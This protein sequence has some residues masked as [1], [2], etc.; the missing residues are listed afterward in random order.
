MEHVGQSM[1]GKAK[2]FIDMMNSN[3]RPVEDH[4]P[5]LRPTLEALWEAKQAAQV[6]YDEGRTKKSSLAAQLNA[7]NKEIVEAREQVA[8]A[9]SAQQTTIEL[10][11][12]DKATPADLARAKQ[13]VTD[14][15]AAEVSLRDVHDTVEKALASV[16]K[17]FDTTRAYSKGAAQRYWKAV[18][19]DL[20]ADLKV[21]AG[22]QIMR[23]YA[24]HTASSNGSLPFADFLARAFPLPKPADLEKAHEALEAEHAAKF[25][26]GL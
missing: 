14:A 18:C 26:G 5:R 15:R 2:S 22:K 3:P 19:D 8:Q 12:A 24:A 6:A 23:L 11:A 9:A 16:V 4:A 7:L 13:A 1:A 17:D 20:M 21:I 10:A 25:G